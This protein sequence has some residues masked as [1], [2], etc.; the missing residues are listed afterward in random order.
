MEPT[1][2]EPASP[3][4]ARHTTAQRAVL[5]FNIVV[6]IACLVGAGALIYG[7]D[8]LDGRL[9]TTKVVINTSTSSG[10]VANT[11]DTTAPGDTSVTDSATPGGTF[12]VADPKAK[13]FLI[14]GSD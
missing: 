12:P 8:Q 7:K 4:R 9:Q 13:N 3:R 10:S 1:P 11:D 14:T 2:T 6:V 5:T